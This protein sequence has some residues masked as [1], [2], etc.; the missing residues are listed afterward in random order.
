VCSVQEK[1]CVFS[2]RKK[3][4]VQDVLPELPGLK[5][6]SQQLQPPPLP[7]NNKA[8]KKL[9]FMQIWHTAMEAQ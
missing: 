2:T 9:I 1:K 3:N 4:V 6:W 5:A 8:E 7:H